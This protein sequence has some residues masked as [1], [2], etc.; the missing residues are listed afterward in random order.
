MYEMFKLE[1]FRSFKGVGFIVAL[2]FGC[3][4]SVAQWGVEILPL[5]WSQEAYMASGLQMIYPHSVYTSWI[6]SHTY[7]FSYLFFMI[8]PLIAVLPFGDSFFYDIKNRFIHDVCTRINRK[9]YYFSKYAAVFISGGIV[10]EIPL[11]LNFFLTSAVLPLLKPQT[12]DYMTSIGMKSTFGDFFFEHPLLYV[13]I[14]LIIIFIFSGAISTLSLVGTYYVNYRFIVLIIPFLFFLFLNSIFG[15]LGLY[16]WE[17]VLFLNPAYS[18]NRILPIIVET[19]GILIF[20]FYL[21]VIRGRK[22]DIC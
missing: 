18:G 8:L 3:L 2:V 1:M 16:D 6:G 22:E 19:A 21:F 7:T 11:I 14:F 5:C 20:T 13:S 10:V 9:N 12:A 15:M 4:V 17:P